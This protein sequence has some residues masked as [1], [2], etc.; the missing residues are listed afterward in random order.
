MFLLRLLPFCLVLLTLVPLSALASGEEVFDGLELDEIGVP[1]ADGVDSSVAEHSV[2]GAA[3]EGVFEFSL[4]ERVGGTG[5]EVGWD[6]WDRWDGFRVQVWC[7][8]QGV[9]RFVRGWRA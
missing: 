3:G 7:L 6:F 8:F 9:G 4:D 5:T 2:E 1:D